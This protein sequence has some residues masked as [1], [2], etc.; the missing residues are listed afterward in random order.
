MA[1]MCTTSSL[2]FRVSK[3]ITIIHTPPPPLPNPAADLIPKD[4]PHYKAFLLVASAR[5]I[6]TA[7]SPITAEAI[8]GRIRAFFREP[9]EVQYVFSHGID[10][11]IVVA[12]EG[13]YEV[14]DVLKLSVRVV[15]RG[16][17]LVDGEWVELE[18]QYRLVC[19]GRN[20]VC[21][22]PALG[23]V[24]TPREQCDVQIAKLQ[25]PKSGVDG[26]RTTYFKLIT[27]FL[28]QMLQ[29][30][31]VH[32]AHA[33]VCTFG[34]DQSIDQTSRNTENRLALEEYFLVRPVRDQSTNPT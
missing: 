4:H 18:E 13:L 30:G 23:Y 22:L 31:Q 15:G 32:V 27:Y 2:P 12:E 19:K 14:N 17:G 21:S 11:W 6:L 10:R 5:P 24:I 16:E 25:T 26:E 20:F 3:S 34:M 28:A 8:H 7:C 29:D 33:A 9:K 1:T